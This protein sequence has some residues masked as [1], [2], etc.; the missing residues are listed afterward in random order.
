MYEKH[1]RYKVKSCL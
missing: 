1:T